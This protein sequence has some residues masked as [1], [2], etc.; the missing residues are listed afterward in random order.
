MLGRR[1]RIGIDVGDDDIYRRRRTGSY[2][3]GGEFDSLSARRYPVEDVEFTVQDLEP[4]PR[5]ETEQVSPVFR[6]SMLVEPSPIIRRMLGLPGT[7][8]GSP[9]G[10]TTD[11]LGMLADVF[12]PRM[13]RGQ[14]VG[15]HIPK[16]YTYMPTAL[17]FDDIKH[18]RYVGGAGVLRTRSR[19]ARRGA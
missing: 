15:L 9:T 14:G 4:R 1:P 6:K 5:E 18:G 11:V 12:A 16:A 19:M 7:L 10:F 13:Y 3:A 17:T 2:L 8:I